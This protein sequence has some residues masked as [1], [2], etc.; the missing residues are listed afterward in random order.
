MQNSVNPE[1]MKELITNSKK[2]NIFQVSLSSLL[3]FHNQIQSRGQN[4]V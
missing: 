3:Q 4:E 2:H 1:N